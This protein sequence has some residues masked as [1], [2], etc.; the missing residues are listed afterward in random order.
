MHGYHMTQPCRRHGVIPA[1][2]ALV[3]V[4]TAY[5]RELSRF[6]RIANR[7]DNLHVLHE[8]RCAEFDIMRLV[9]PGRRE[10]DSSMRLDT[11]FRFHKA[12][13]AGLSCQIRT[14][15][16]GAVHD[17]NLDQAFR[18]AASH[19][20]VGFSLRGYQA[21][22][23]P[24]PDTSEFCIPSSSFARIED[25]DTVT[26][27]G[28]AS[29]RHAMS[30]IRYFPA[31]GTM[32]PFLTLNGSSAWR[33][34]YFIEQNTEPLLPDTLMP[35]LMPYK[36]YKKAIQAI[37]QMEATA[38]A[39]LGRQ[40]NMTYVYQAFAMEK[41]LKKSG[42]IQ[43]NLADATIHA[44][45]KLCALSSAY[46]IRKHEE[47][48]IFKSALDSLIA[49]DGAGDAEKL[50][51][52]SQFQV[53]RLLLR[54]S[55]PFFA[56]PQVSLE[57]G[58]T[59]FTEGIRYEKTYP[60]DQFNRYDDTL[61]NAV[62]VRG[63]AAAGVRGSWGIAVSERWFLDVACEK[64]L[65]SAARSLEFF[66]GGTFDAA[67]LVQADWSLIS[68]YWVST[69]LL[70]QTAFEHILALVAVP[71]EWPYHSW[72]ALDFLI[73]DNFSLRAQFS[74]FNARIADRSYITAI[75]APPYHG[76]GAAF[77]ASY[78]F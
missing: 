15:R 78:G 1:V 49:L 50:K 26:T 27:Q 9:D 33:A 72:L 38:G 77:T 10:V 40:K 3:L 36:Y 17:F 16:S 65:V 14:S 62:L 41:E 69:R 59:F 45:A 12:I 39:G 66:P 70:V 75:A 4:P 55:P 74:L 20:T 58:G 22:P 29:G 76:L 61:K 43:F 64:R 67:N 51:Y 56:G 57:A 8:Y 47:F 5:G 23:Q 42:V 32:A 71:N 53:K 48:R 35:D 25:F 24:C 31:R 2:F 30:L 37:G 28:G 46:R 54:N 21:P 44:I 18:L 13:D 6:K 63:G 7:Y 34:A 52:F 11:T 68:A 19:T 73:E 60:Y